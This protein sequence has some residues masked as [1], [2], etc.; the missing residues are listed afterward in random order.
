MA[1]TKESKE[2]ARARAQTADAEAEATAAP[3]TLSQD[4]AV[5]HPD[6]KEWW[7]GAEGDTVPDWALT[8][9]GAGMFSPVVEDQPEVNLGPVPGHGQS[10]VPP[11][12]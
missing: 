5:Q 6:T 4:V 8:V 2:T 1:E 9:L 12:S 11:E 3:R 7:H 10:F